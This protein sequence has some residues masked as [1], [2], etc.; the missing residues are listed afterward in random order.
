MRKVQQ[1][2]LVSA[3]VAVMAMHGQALAQD[4][5]EED[6]GIVV[7]ADRLEEAMP[8]QVERYGARLEV[9]Q[10]EAIDRGGFVDTS[11]ALQMLVPGLYVAPRS[12]VFDYVNVS[13]LGSRSSEVLFL[14]DGVRI[15]NRLYAGT[16]PLDTLPAHMIERI[17][18]LKGGQGLYYGTQAVGGIINVVTKGFTAQTDGAVEFGYNTNQGYG[19]N[20]HA[21]GSA[22]NHYFVG[23]A[24]HDQAEGFR[25]FHHEDYQPSAVDR[26]RGY[27]MTTF[28]AKYAFEPS[29]A[30]RLSASYQHTEGWVD[31]PQPVNVYDNRNFRNE[32]IVSLK[33][34]WSP[35]D[36]LDVF[37]KGYWHDWDSTYLQLFTTLGPDGQPTGAIRTIFDGEKWGFTDRGLNVLAEY[38][39]GGGVTLVGGYDF[40]RYN[41]MD[42]VFLI[43][44]T[45]EEVHAPFAQ[46]R[47]DLPVAAGL[48]LA[49]GVR[50][51]MPSDAQSKT[52]WNASGRLALD[53]N[54][55]VRGQVGTSFRLP[56]AYE[57]YVI[58]PCCETGNPN[59]VGEESFN[60]ELGIG[61]QG[62]RI[63]AEVL[64]F[65][66]RTE[67]LI[68]IDFSLPAYPDGFIVNT[69]DVVKAWGGEV[70]V[71]AQL[72]E[73]FGV[74]L[75][76]TRTEVKMA[77]TGMQI[78]NI[79][80]DMAKAILRAQ[81]PGG[82]FGASA[83]FNWVGDVYSNVAGGI[84]RVEH[85]NYALLDLSAWAFL[86]AAQRHRVGL[87]LENAFDTDYA[88][89][90]TRFRRDV[91]NA[92]YAAEFRGTPMTLHASY[93]LSL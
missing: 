7:L 61:F 71:N 67:N 8:L 3:A 30:F 88:T 52:V 21:R 39:L 49:A 70:I 60:T 40:Q 17:E 13:L 62:G 91:T 2:L 55:F 10:G 89:R 92:S 37:V 66:R 48:A 24:S 11:Q 90:A 42:D 12:G 69:A 59:L 5:A 26:K 22:G 51:N 63:S 18:V 85:G 54:W 80:K 86:D 84:G 77:G 45:A 68:G 53:D 41:G 81:A 20:G 4:A 93:R 29:T 31:F 25:P 74:T 76:Y 33:V 65:H 78:V 1:A 36:A 27:E 64:G 32:E 58:D 34:D 73:V 82:R 35:T 15:S 38:G 83:A 28:G 56:T 47:L 19:I 87:R 14:V 46:V 75:D 57:L 43:A 16:T 6:E 50:H 9:V 23:F 44:P 79:P 72:S